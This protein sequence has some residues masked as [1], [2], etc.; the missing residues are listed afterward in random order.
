MTTAMKKQLIFLFASASLVLG[1]CSEKTQDDGVPGYGRLSVRCGADLSLASRAEAEP[2]GD[3]FALALD[4]EGYHG[5]WAT[6]AGFAAQDTLFR[7]GTY[8]ATVT[9]GDPAAEGVGKPYYTGTASVEIVAR[10]TAEV[11]IEAKIANSQVLVTATE[12]FLHYFH[13]PQFAVTTGTGNIFGFVPGRVPADETVCVQAGTALSVKGSARKQSQTG[14]DEGIEVTF[15]EQRVASTASRTRY[16]FEYDAPDAGSAILV[17][18]MN[19]EPVETVVLDL[20][21]NDGAIPDTK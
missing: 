10:R 14:T 11:T 6:V 19:D 12:Q 1:A 15:D 8:T 16:T 20:E 9:Y 3:A 18:K 7:E 2:A 5:Q 13:T 17:I 4:G 21:M